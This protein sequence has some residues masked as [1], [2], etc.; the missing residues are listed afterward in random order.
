MRLRLVDRRRPL[1]EP[2]RCEEVV[3][4]RQS[5]D[6]EVGIYKDSGR[7]YVRYQQAEFLIDKNLV[8]VTCRRRGN[9]SDAA[10]RHLF[11]G[12]VVSHVLNARGCISLH[13]SAVRVRGEVIAFVA[14]P[15]TG[16]STLAGH[17]VS[18]GA[19]L[20]GDDTL[21]LKPRNRF[22][23]SL[24]G[25]AQLRLWPDAAAHQVWPDGSVVEVD[26]LRPQKQNVLLPR[27]GAHYCADSLPLRHLYV[28]ERDSSIAEARVEPMTQR[29]TLLTLVG[30]IHGNFLANGE[31]LS[32]QL[33]HLSQALTSFTARRLLVPQGLEKL[34]A[35]RAAVLTDTDGY[36]T[37]A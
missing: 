35:A 13:A 29:E 27:S 33:G 24:P 8:E 31:A 32:D 30:S 20:V 34:P 3:F 11:L 37:R 9:C 12:L 25:P 23:W 26:P 2:R 16:K 4:E 14:T 17:F 1:L 28:I 7:V 19:A 15:G 10:L 22:L 21:A 6:G 5:A 18:T 36:T